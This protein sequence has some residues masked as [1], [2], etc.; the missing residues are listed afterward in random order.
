MFLSGVFYIN[1]ARESDRRVQCANNLRLIGLVLHNYH[2]TWGFPPPYVTDAQGKPLYS[3][4]V[5]ILPW[6]EEQDLYSQWRLDEPW[7]SPHNR[8]LP[9]PSCFSC[10]TAERNRPPGSPPYTDYLAVVGPGMAWEEDKCLT[11]DDFTD[12]ASNTAMVVEVRGSQ[13]HW[14]EPVDFDGTGSLKINASQGLSIGSHHPDGAHFLFA[15][16]FV[17]QLADT[18]S[19]QEI[20]TLLTRAGAE[21]LDRDGD[22]TVVAHEFGRLRWSGESW[23]GTDKDPFHDLAFS[24][25]FDIVD[26]TDQEKLLAIDAA[27]KAFR[28]LRHRHYTNLP[29]REK[30]RLDVAREVTEAAYCQSN[31]TPTDEDVQRLADDMTMESWGMTYATDDATASPYFVYTSPNCF[32]NKRIRILFS[33]DFAIDEVTVTE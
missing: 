2:D 22:G 9:A 10:P 29:G 15:D 5:L 12:V 3:W 32:P 1:W 8:S 6:M 27:R 13:V 30:T 4:R 17:L 21:H 31:D 26:P 11:F 19:E 25:D 20:K 24:I 23:E 28:R 16:G 14:A 7:D 33:T 18:T